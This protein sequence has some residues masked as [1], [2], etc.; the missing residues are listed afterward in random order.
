MLPYSVNGAPTQPDLFKKVCVFALIYMVVALHTPQLPC[1]FISGIN[2]PCPGCTE[3]LSCAFLVVLG[4]VN[5][6]IETVAA[7][8]FHY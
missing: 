2:Q 5:A 4:A 1:F 7:I 8:R 3:V 6:N